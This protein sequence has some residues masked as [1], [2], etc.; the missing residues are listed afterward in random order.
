[1][2]NRA[3][4]V[5]ARLDAIERKLDAVIAAIKI[6]VGPHCRRMGEHITF[7]EG[8][9]NVARTPLAWLSSR[10]GGPVEYPALEGRDDVTEVD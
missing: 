1:M 3:G 9:Y 7:V 5:V 4:C 6:D 2:N 10:L 8:V